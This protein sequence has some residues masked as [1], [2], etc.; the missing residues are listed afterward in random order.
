MLHQHFAIAGMLMDSDY[1]EKE[2]EFAYGSSALRTPSYN[3]S[4]TCAGPVCTRLTIIVP[5]KHRMHWYLAS[6]SHSRKRLPPAWHEQSIY[7]GL[8]LQFNGHV[9]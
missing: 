9:D 2:M 3:L 7:D 6:N 1:F 8:F 4:A 5:T